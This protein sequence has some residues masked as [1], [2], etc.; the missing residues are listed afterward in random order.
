MA[1][2]RGRFKWDFSGNSNGIKRAKSIIK[3]WNGFIYT[4]TSESTGSPNADISSMNEGVGAITLPPIVSTAGLVWFSCSCSTRVTV[5]LGPKDGYG[6]F[7]RN[8]DQVNIDPY[9]EGSPVGWS[10]YW[11]SDGWW[12]YYDC[13]P[14]CW[15]Y[16]S[17]GANTYTVNRCTYSDFRRRGSLGILVTKGTHIVSGRASILVLLPQRSQGNR[18]WA[19]FQ[20][21]IWNPIAE[22]WITGNIQ[23][24]RQTLTDSGHLLITPAELNGYSFPEI[25]FADAVSN[26]AF[27]N[28][29]SADQLKEAE[30]NIKK[31]HLDNLGTYYVPLAHSN[32]T[33]ILIKKAPDDIIV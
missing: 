18:N 29:C 31:I 3:Q 15:I 12:V 26:P 11:T 6:R 4:D 21:Y 2:P 17:F 20:M 24:I 32:Q 5:T 19:A 7:R 33:V 1:I 28:Y 13:T 10:W 25:F 22:S 9:S 30:W 16:Q 27:G 14:N 23:G 8:G